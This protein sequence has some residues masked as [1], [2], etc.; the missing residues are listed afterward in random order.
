M[1]IQK[2]DNQGPFYLQM[3]IFW[4]DFRRNWIPKLG[5]NGY[6]LRGIFNKCVGIVL[7]AFSRTFLTTWI[8]VIIGF[9]TA[10]VNCTDM[11]RDHWQVQ[12]QADTLTALQEHDHFCFC[13]FKF[14]HIESQG[15]LNPT[16][17]TKLLLLIQ[18]RAFIKLNR[19]CP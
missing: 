1:S 13:K 4:Q 19:I 7:W 16:W 2:L 10:S 12:E 3:S 14:H 17:L 18:L 9:S 15:Y 5:I 6:L 11:F 8:E